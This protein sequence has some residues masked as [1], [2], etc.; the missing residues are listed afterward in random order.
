MNAPPEKESR[1]LEPTA[2]TM[3][4][5]PEWQT[6]QACQEAIWKSE[7]IRLLTLYEVTGNKRHLEAFNRHLAGVRMRRGAG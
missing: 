6:A 5:V 3:K 1:R 7:A 4:S 2:K